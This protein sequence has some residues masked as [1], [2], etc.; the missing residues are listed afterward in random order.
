[1]AK[2]TILCLGVLAAAISSARALTPEELTKIEGDMLVHVQDCAKKF[3]VDESDLKKAKEEENIDGVDPCL[4]G[5]VF[6]NIK[7]VNDKGLYD[8]DVA[9]ES[10]KSYLSDDADKAKFAEI[11]KDCASVNDES[12]SDGEDGCERSKLLLVCFGKHKHLL[13]KE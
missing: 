12:V 2:F 9:I 5:C 8:P 1:M 10:S 4:I 3:D 11:A 13:M 7:L 6:K